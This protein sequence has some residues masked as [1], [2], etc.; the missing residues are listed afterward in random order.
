MQPCVREPLRTCGLQRTDAVLECAQECGPGKLRAHRPRIVLNT[1][2]DALVF[3]SRSSTLG[4]FAA[5]GSGAGFGQ[6]VRID[7]F[8]GLVSPFPSVTV[9][10]DGPPVVEY[11]RFTSGYQAPRHVLRTWMGG[12]FML[13]VQVSAPFAPGEVCDR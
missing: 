4:S 6:S 12:S 5:V 10:A 9:N 7:P 3:W 8:D 13:L 1:D 11:R 2:G